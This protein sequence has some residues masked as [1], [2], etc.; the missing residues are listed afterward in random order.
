MKIIVCIL[1]LL[2]CSEIFG[3]TAP[4]K[5]WIRFTDKDNSIYSLSN[6]SAFLSE[7][8]IERR[9][10]LGIGFNELDLPVKQSYIEGVL[11][12]GNCQLH[13][14]SKWFNAI[15]IT[16]AD[17]SLVDLIEALPFVAEVKSVQVLTS[18]HE[19]ALKK[20]SEQNTLRSAEASMQSYCDATHQHYGPSFR[21]IEML[22]GHLLHE[23]GFTGIGVDIALLDAG[24]NMTDKL[25]A[26]DRMHNENRLIMTRDFV[27]PQS[28][29]VFNSSSHGTY[30]LSHITGHIADSLIGTAPDANFF[31]FKTEDADSEYLVEED[32]W[33]AAAEV[34]DSLGIDIINS[35]LGYSLFDDT[36]MNHTYTDMDGNT[37]HCSI[38][39]DI[40]SHKGI[41]VV[42]SAGN[43]GD[44]PWHYITA[45]SDGDSVLCIGAVGA[46]RQHAWFSSYGPSA[47]GD[48]KPNVCAMGFQTV[49]AALDSTIAM[50]NGTSFSSPIIAGMAACLIQAFP[51]K[52]NMEIKNAIEQSA[53]LYAA[54]N[55]SLG[56]GIPDFWQA[57]L[58]LQGNTQPNEGDLYATVFPNPCNTHLNIIIRVESGCMAS[59]QM[60]NAK[61][62]RVYEGQH[63]IQSGEKGV[64]QLDDALQTL[65]AGHYVLHLSTSDRHSEVPFIVARP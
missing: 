28:T 30:V 55:D 13:N 16:T 24:W 22:N 32:N 48:V 4:G 51:L 18:T 11:A 56:Y 53:H 5:Y 3:Q 10:R 50:G 2:F 49:F 38:A 52:S 45:P 25:P 39:A 59:Y 46:E 7:K 12:A 42:N 17:T 14:K 31:L 29:T 27:N 57:F 23:F 36:L 54:P 64:L 65:S 19:L 44:N 40:A 33:V 58:I 9:I 62:Q 35:S 21:Q 6:P 15:T 26:F 8:C 47:D 63:F 60:F 41:L 37:T 43:S 20:L 34:C 1:S 61:G